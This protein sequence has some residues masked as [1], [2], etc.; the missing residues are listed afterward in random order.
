MSLDF[1]C[2]G[3][4][5]DRTVGKYM[6]VLVHKQENLSPDRS[7]KVKFAPCLLK[8]PGEISVYCVTMNK[9]NRVT[10]ISDDEK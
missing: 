9:L 6:P 8:L 2:S 10:V 7:V 3:F 4:E 1:Q 5:T